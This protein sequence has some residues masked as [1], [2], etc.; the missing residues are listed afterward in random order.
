MPGK[1]QFSKVDA[2]EKNEFNWLRNSV[3]WRPYLKM[4]LSKTFIDLSTVSK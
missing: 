3:E 1:Y 4:I 2:E